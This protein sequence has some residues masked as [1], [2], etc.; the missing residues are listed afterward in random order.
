MFAPA[1]SSFAQ[2]LETPPA[3]PVPNQVV[4]APAPSRVDTLLA[5]LD[6]ADW[7]VRQ[8]AT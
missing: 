6:A 1:L 4:D 3:P 2:A 7:S 5:D 8:R